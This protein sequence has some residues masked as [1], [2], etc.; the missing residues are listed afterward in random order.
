M[1]FY[2][3]TLVRVRVECTFE[4]LETTSGRRFS[5][6]LQLH[7]I[8]LP[9]LLGIDNASPSDEQS[10]SAW[11]DFLLGTP[12]DKKARYM[13]NAL[14]EKAERK[15]T[16]LS[17]DPAVRRLALD[18]ERDQLAYHASGAF[19]SNRSALWNYNVRANVSVAPQHSGG[20]S[21]PFSSRKQQA[22]RRT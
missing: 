21:S 14:I 6:A 8:E 19:S 7:T 10:L 2:A 5:P 20:Q 15:L 11:S 17:A 16:E 13:S 12:H 3:T 9:R 1:L 4:V 18:R 22:G